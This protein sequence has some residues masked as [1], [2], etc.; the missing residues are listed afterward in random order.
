[1]CQQRYIYGEIRLT[2]LNIIS[3][4]APEVPG[5]NGYVSG[6]GQASMFFRRNFAWMGLGFLYLIAILTAMRV[7]LPAQPLKD[8]VSFNWAPYGFAVFCILLP[9]TIV[10]VHF[11]RHVLHFI[12]IFAG[13]M[14]ETPKRSKKTKQSV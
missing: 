2:R 10:A 4:Y 5:L 8:S 6:Y 9:V 13:M 12:S 3:R 7:G 1:M 11:L 14:R